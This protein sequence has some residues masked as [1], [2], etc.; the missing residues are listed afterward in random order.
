MKTNKHPVTP[1]RGFRNQRDQGFALIATISI[2]ILMVL[3]AVGLL[4]L[5]TVALRASSEAAAMG[6]ARANA[7]MALMIAIGELQKHAGPD[8]RVTAMGGIVGDKV[9]QPNWTGVWS[10]QDDD[11]LPVWLVSGNELEDVGDLDELRSH[12][13]GYQTPD[14][15]PSEE[16][17]EIFK[18][19]ESG[20]TVN[21]SLVKVE[22]DRPNAGQYGWWVSDE[23]SKA[24]VDVQAPLEA[25]SGSSLRLA[26]AGSAQEPNFAE[27]GAELEALSDRSGELNK[28]KLASYGSVELVL[29]GD[30]AP[31]RFAHHLTAGGYGLP[32]NVV[33]GGM[34]TD[35]SVL[36][37]KSQEG[38]RR[39]LE[40]YLGAIPSPKKL[41]SNGAPIYQFTSVSAPDTFYLSPEL[42]TERSTDVGPNWGNLYNYGKLWAHVGSGSAEPFSFDP[43]MVSDMRA[44]TW[45]P[46]TKHNKGEYSKDVQHTNSSLAP[47]LSVLQMGFRFTARE[48]PIPDT[49]PVVMGYQLQLQMK[50]LVGFW[51][52]YNVKLR[53]APKSMQWALYPH[54]RVN[55][56]TARIDQSDHRFSRVNRI[57]TDVWMRENWLQGGGVATADNQA[58]RR[59]KL[60][61]DAID[62][63]PGEFRLFSVEDRAKMERVNKL[64]PT[65][66][67]TG[68]FDF[69]LKY[70]A[71]SSGDGTFDQGEPGSP[72][73]VPKGTKVFYGMAYLEDSV[74]PRTRE[75][76][77]DE[78]FDGATS[79]YIQVGGSGNS[80]RVADIWQ[81]MS[82]SG[83]S[84]TDIQN[85]NTW[86]VPEPVFSIWVKSG[87]ANGG[88]VPESSKLPVEL[89]AQS[90]YHVGTWRFFS[91]TSSEAIPAER[92]AGSQ[93]LRS[94]VDCNPRYG[95]MNPA[96]DGSKTKDQQANGF[97]FISP[98]IGGTF[99]TESWDSGP[100]G[101]GLVAEGQDENGS[102]P[103]AELVNG[104]YRGFGGLASTSAGVSNVPLFDVPRAPLVSLGQLQHAQVSRYG[105]EPAFPIGNSHASIHVPLDKTY[106]DDFAEF[107]NFRMLDLSYSMNRS[108]W[109][110]NF[111]STIG[112]DYFDRDSSSLD[113]VLPFDELAG[114]ELKL[115]NPRHLFIPIGGDESLDEIVGSSAGTGAKEISARIGILGAFNVN[116][117]SIPA[118]K[119]VL[120]SMEDFEFPVIS[121]DGGSVSWED[122]GGIRLP[123]FGHVMQ[124]EGWS[125]SSGASDPAF[126]NGFREISDEELDEL[127][128]GIVE[129][130][131]ARGPFRSFADFVNRDPESDDIDHQ[132]MGAMQAAL[133]RSLNAKL[134]GDV[135]D[136]VERPQ[137]DTFSN[138]MSPEENTAA[139]YASYQLQGDVLQTLAPVLQVRGDYFRVRAVGQATDGSGNVTATAVCEAYVQRTANYIDPREEV[140]LGAEDLK[141]KINEKFG[142]RFEI[143]SFKWLSTTEI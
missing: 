133:D 120:A 124:S 138:A 88:S 20:D 64:V 15:G 34:K 69:D 77:G 41:T 61:T 49:D 139:G 66:N 65:W 47:I 105:Y 89:I 40:N 104:R 32:V 103:E 112:V 126:W 131:R 83:R 125:S 68:G 86:T 13:T 63:E 58:G 39:L 46:Y 132:R 130:V 19:I 106:V 42:S 142:R 93:R 10:T 22:S 50:P 102:F 95:P 121:E 72:I 115:P 71:A 78:V 57:R 14:S 48:A 99:V 27:M 26:R 37:D 74:K 84:M 136:K 24:R 51:N 111:F 18:G 82:E 97:H 94:W 12:P 137:G 128:V 107:E 33:N 6:T 75:Y 98:F 73:I 9:E 29:D 5:S 110:D 127:A 2:M 141:Q 118:W 119:A 100:R 23:G 60:E 11:G 87:G 90:P 28:E 56:D 101:R 8:Q 122:E 135:G 25:A 113:D 16:S 59:I 108:L 114:G 140:H 43:H 36:F 123:R 1:V 52:P 70:S 54:I 80:H 96:W 92:S 67:E 45:A 4:S 21:V 17:V 116:S 30:E 109:D 134:A 79:S 44:N 53:A 91:R 85:G 117:T 81:P 35:L 38:N 143:A 129:E 7:R 31:R 55:A 76:F 3:L 62:F